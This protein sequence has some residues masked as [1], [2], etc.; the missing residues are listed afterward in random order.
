MAT[1]ANLESPRMPVVTVLPA[2][3]VANPPLDMMTLPENQESLLIPKQAKQTDI[4]VTL[5][6]TV[7]MQR[8]ASQQTAPR[9]PSLAR[10]TTCSMIRSHPSRLRMVMG[11]ET[12][13]TGR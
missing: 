8:A 1:M 4:L 2:A 3:R 9:H 11:M 13:I 6:T 5:M 12:K 7:L 10:V